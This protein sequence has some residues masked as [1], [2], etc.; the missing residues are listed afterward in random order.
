MILLDSNIWIYALDAATPEHQAAHSALEA[1]QD[2]GGTF[3]MPAVVQ[4]EVVHY[5]RRLMG[6]SADGPVERLIEFPGERRPL[7][8]YGVRAG[9]RI[10]SA[11]A[12]GRIGMRDG[13]ILHHAKQDKATLWT[14]DAALLVVARAN[15]VVAEDPVAP[16]FSP[17]VGR[18]RNMPRRSRARKGV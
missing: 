17:K 10:A 9:Y 4:M 8:R 2:A 5:L 11:V 13:M 16:G 15:G 18:P 1:C 3:L 6:P 12:S 7:D 14:H